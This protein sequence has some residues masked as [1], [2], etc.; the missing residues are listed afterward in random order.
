MVRPLP[1]PDFSDLVSLAKGRKTNRTTWEIEGYAKNSWFCSGANSL[2]NI[3]NQSSK[4]SDDV[5]LMLPAYFCGQSLKYLR[6][7][8]VIFIFYNLHDDLTPNYE[9]IKKILQ[10]QKPD[11]F[12]HVHYFGQI[13]KQSSTREL[14]DNFNM[15]MV[16][17]C[18]HVLHP[19]VHNHWVGDYIFFSP[20]KF[21]PVNNASVIFSNYKMKINSLCREESLPFLWFL[22]RLLKR[23]FLLNKRKT[24][25]WKVQ[26]SS[27]SKFP[28]FFTPNS[29]VIDLIEV[30]SNN[31]NEIS[32]IR[33]KNR[34]TLLSS[35][36]QFKKWEVLSNFGE[37]DIPYILGMKCESEI[38]ASELYCKFRS[39]G[40]PVMMWPDLP[41]ELRQSTKSYSLDIERTTLTIFFFLHEQIDIDYYLKLI[42]QVLNEK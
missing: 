39:C 13:L 1:L 30:K 7:A 16:E 22:N 25:T 6:N 36:V 27:Q 20:H 5:H 42:H 8:G 29:K 10:V 24:S 19:S 37:K 40:C 26:W 33:V 12:L 28:G 21:F 14:C 15:T 34:K 17:D 31:I 2:L 3:C 38:V 41:Y 35:L 4:G 32:K 23:Y 18:A 9:H 11:I